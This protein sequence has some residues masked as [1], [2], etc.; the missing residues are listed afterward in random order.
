MC[1][2]TESVYAVS[3]T[4]IFARAAGPGRQYLAYEM[5]FG[6]A[7]ET[8]MIL[9]LPVASHDERT[10]LRFIDL[11]ATPDFFDR[12]ASMIVM[13]EEFQMGAGAGDVDM[14]SLGTEEVRPPLLVHEVGAF[15]ASFVPTV[16]DFD[17]LDARFRL[18]PDV[19]SA[20]PQQY[21]DYGFAVFRL[22]ATDG[23]ALHAHP[24]A[25][26]FSTRFDSQLF[27]PTVHVHDGSVPKL[28]WFD[29]IIYA[30]SVRWPALQ[31][32]YYENGVRG[33]GARKEVLDRSWSVLRESGD[34]RY[35]RATQNEHAKG[36]M[37]CGQSADPLAG[38][39]MRG[40]PA[41]ELFRQ[42]CEI[43]MPAR[44]QILRVIRDEAVLAGD[45]EVSPEIRKIVFEATPRERQTWIEI[46]RWMDVAQLLNIQFAEL[47]AWYALSESDRAQVLAGKWPAGNDAGARKWAALDESRQ[48]NFARLGHWE[49]IPPL[50]RTS[51]PAIRAW[52]ALPPET[53]DLV[54]QGVNLH[55]LF[56]LL[57]RVPEIVRKHYGHRGSGEERRE[58]TEALLAAEPREEKGARQF[59]K[60]VDVV[61]WTILRTI[62]Q[63]A[64][65]SP[66]FDASRKLHALGL[67][68][69][70]AN[71]DVLLETAVEGDRPRPPS[72]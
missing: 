61:T 30:Q 8:A 14:L 55:K 69:M 34:W 32:G 29:H 63:F 13:F 36:I 25:F 50:M 31:A 41:D 47:E 71:E 51:E 46:K 38:L 27:I 49:E 4:R 67:S 11:S 57:E 70:L 58:V 64:G 23:K 1:I 53:R 68:G 15:D 65:M 39:R 72:S 66:V 52:T 56:P 59:L 45:D 28:A 22:R 9:P 26:E 37:L 7:T 6:A 43:P 54:W 48:K 40:A 18:P 5:S 3:D 16:A 24:M 12:L 42:W 33:E 44:S 10:A 62:D 2:F 17:R 35:R 20:L 19:W 60:E 21:R